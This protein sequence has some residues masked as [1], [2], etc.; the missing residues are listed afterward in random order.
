MLLTEPNTQLPILITGSSAPAVKRLADL[1]HDEPDWNVTTLAVTSAQPLT[2]ALAAAAAPDGAMRAIVVA[3]GDGDLRVLE[4]LAT[5]DH[6]LHAPV[7]VC[8]SLQSV[9]ATRAAMRA[10]AADLLSESPEPSDLV[11]ALQ[12]AVLQPPRHNG[13][14]ELGRMV[15]IIG[16]AGGVGTSFIACTLAHLSAAVWHRRTLLIDSDPLYATLGA[17]LGLKPKRGLTEALQQL[18][19]LDATAL[20]GYITRHPSSLGLMSCVE[21]S[22][23]APPVDGNSFSTLLQL[24]REGHEQVFMEGRRWLDPE[25]VAGVNDSQHVLL[26]LEQSVLH[27]HNAARL[28]QLLTQHLNVPASR[29]TVVLNRYSRR[30]NVQPETLCKVIGCADPVLIPSMHG[31]A[32]DSMDAA[33]PLFDLDRKSPLSRALINLGSKLVENATTEPDGLLRRAMSAISIRI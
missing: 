26:V 27:V 1:L 13:A 29:I 31:L 23:I 8:G 33:I 6:K 17:A 15:T 2:D 16:A 19:S 28:F 22:A 32:L 12:R 18:E 20:Q 9:D 30:A 10:G 7:I 5:L 4:A 24:I 14:H 3:G 21:D 11:S 25:T